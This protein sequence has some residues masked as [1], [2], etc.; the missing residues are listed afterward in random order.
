MIEHLHAVATHAYYCGELDA[1]RRACERLLR[2]EL[3]PGMERIVR[4]NR[5]WYTHRLEELASTRFIRLDAETYT[6]WSLFNPSIVA[7]DAGWVCNVRSSNYRIVNGC[8]EMPAADN[9]VI[10]TENVL[11]YLAD[12]FVTRSAVRVLQ[13]YERT[14]F[15]VDGL[16]D[17]RLNVVDGQKLLSA[18]VRNF[19]PHDGT[20]RIATTSLSGTIVCP[21]TEPGR[22]EKNWMPILGRAEWLYACHNAGHVATVREDGGYW[23]VTNHA[24]APY[25]AR[26][27]RGGSQLVPVG[28]G[29]WLA[30]VHEVAEDDTEGG[31]RIYEH[32]FVKF[33]EGAGWAIAGV[34]PPFSFM[35]PRAIEF[36]AGLARKG[37]RIVASFGLRD[38]EAWLVEMTLG[39]VLNL[40]VPL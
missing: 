31:R 5:T 40:V 3:P 35:E 24:A 12:D 22:H 16:E 19:A 30:L 39:E 9:G 38:A 34:S 25:L 29:H 36:A 1:G 32:R 20:C 13:D 17:I 14:D 6:G 23:Q 28:N 26:G 2:H 7:T 37:D 21:P 27:F 18:T 4:R 15:P 8:Y 10:R 11:L 33:D